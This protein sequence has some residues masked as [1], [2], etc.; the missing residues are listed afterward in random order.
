MQS[1]EKDNVIFIRLFSNEDLY[2]KLNE[3]CKMHNVKTAVVL[4]GIGQL[5]K[6]QLGYFK[7][8]NNYA[9]EEFDLPHEL[10]AL[11]GNICKQDEDYIFHFHAVLGDE[12][13]NTIGGHLIKGNVE[14]TNEIVLLKTWINVNRKFEEKTGLKGMFVE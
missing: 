10:L 14:I 3:A 13:K 6:F 7:G 2:G 9:Q 4:S 5:K 12:K 11:N 8:K 1:T